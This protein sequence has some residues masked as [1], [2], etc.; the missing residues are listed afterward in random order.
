MAGNGTPVSTLA[1]RITIDDMQAVESLRGIKN[2]V[3]SLMNSWKAQ[4]A[5][6][7]SV[8]DHLGA[9]K[10]KYEGLGDAI[11]KQEEYISKLKSEMETIDTSTNKGSEAYARLTKQLSMAQKQLANLN[12]QKNAQKNQWI[13]MLVGLIKLSNR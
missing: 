2:Q 7:N 1:T 11:Q 9:A 12:A 10:A 3:S 8:G 5:M 4:N 6:L 13:T